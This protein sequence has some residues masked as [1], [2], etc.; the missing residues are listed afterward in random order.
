MRVN[1]SLCAVL[2]DHVG[3]REG[4]IEVADDATLADAITR[5]DLASGLPW[6][7]CVNGRPA[8]NETPLADGDRLYLFLPVSGG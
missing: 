2:R 1:V 7:A 6:I 3:G 8:P 5:L 4:D